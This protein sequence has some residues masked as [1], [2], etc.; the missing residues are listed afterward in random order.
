MSEHKSK[1]W[2]KYSFDND[3]KSKINKNLKKNKILN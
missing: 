2:D 3:E 1:E